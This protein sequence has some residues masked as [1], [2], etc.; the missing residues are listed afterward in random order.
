[1]LGGVTLEK[2]DAVSVMND[3]SPPSLI[4]QAFGAE[5]GM[6]VG[7]VPSLQVTVTSL[8][9]PATSVM[10]ALLPACPVNVILIAGLKFRVLSGSPNDA[11]KIT[12]RPEIVTV[13]SFSNERSP[14]HPALEISV[15]A[16]ILTWVV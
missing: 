14:S 8:A 10:N 2:V 12:L 1:V 6:L 15:L 9:V 3:K 13:S 4:L 11:L 7:L 16:G 5:V